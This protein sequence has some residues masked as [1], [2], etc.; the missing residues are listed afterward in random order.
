DEQHADAE[1]VQHPH[2]ERRGVR[3]V[4]FVHVKAA[5]EREH[6]AAGERAMDELAA[7]P[8]SPLPSTIAATGARTPIRPRTP[9]AAA[10]AA[11]APFPLTP[12]P[13]EAA[14][15]PGPRRRGGRGARRRRGTPS[16]IRCGRACRVRRG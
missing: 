11:A 14:R 3:A 15:T 12:P 16:R 13:P 5:R 7:M 10:V 9:S 1:R 4:A 6:L 2:G 8:S